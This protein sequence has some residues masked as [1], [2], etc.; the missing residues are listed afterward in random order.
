MLDLIVLLLLLFGR[1]KYEDVKLE[2]KVTEMVRVRN[3]FRPRHLQFLDK[4]SLEV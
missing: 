4:N 1:L 2:V 3:T